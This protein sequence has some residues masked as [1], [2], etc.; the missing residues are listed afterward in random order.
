VL[1]SVFIGSR[2]RFDEALAH[3][4]AQRTELAGVV[5]TASWRRSRAGRVAFARERLRRRGPLRTLDEALFHLYFH[6]RVMASEQERLEAAVLAPYRALHGDL[7]WTGDALRTDDVNAP[8][9]VAFLQERRPDVAFAV[10]VNHYFGERVRSLPRL[11]TFLWHEGV[12]PEYKGLYSPFWAVHELDLERVGYTLLRMSAE[13]DAGDVFVQG[14]ARDVDP[15]RDHHVFLGHKAIWDSLPEVERFL[16]ELEAGR[17]RPIE[18]PGA[19]AR[20]FTYPGITDFVRQRRRV[21]SLASRA[22]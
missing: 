7:R 8:E 9:V 11:G 22:P 19:S 21:R 18:R 1:R 16:A 2:N 20:T 17:A 4:L 6:R 14:R 13:I 3:W 15:R 12:T 10:C 5:W